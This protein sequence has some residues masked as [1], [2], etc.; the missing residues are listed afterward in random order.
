MI[1]IT[2]DLELAKRFDVIVNIS[3]LRNLKILIGI[4]IH[5]EKQYE[6]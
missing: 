4:T 5:R 6:I 2:H 3:E 1:V